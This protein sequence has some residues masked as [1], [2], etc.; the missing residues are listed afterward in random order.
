[1]SELSEEKGRS[2]SDYPGLILRNASSQLVEFDFSVFGSPASEA[3]EFT[4]IF[5]LVR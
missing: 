5:E 2:L 3:L 4:D 1:M